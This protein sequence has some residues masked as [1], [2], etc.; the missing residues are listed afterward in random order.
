MSE[1]DDRTIPRPADRDDVPQEPTGSSGAL[2]STP[3]TPSAEELLSTWASFT[4][5]A[6]GISVR[7]AD[8]LDAAGRLTLAEFDVLVRLHREPT[9]RLPTVRL[10]EEVGLTAGGLIKLADRMELDGLL[11]RERSTQDRRVV[12]AILTDHGRQVTAKVLDP[13]VA[14]LRRLLLAPLGTQGL[15]AL[16]ALSRALRDQPH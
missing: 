4:E 14:D 6:V 8:G 11:V 1:D 7:L 5:A 9:H 10:A 15:R 13:F 12:L 3:G 2:L 16:A